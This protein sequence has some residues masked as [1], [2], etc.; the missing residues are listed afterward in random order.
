[1][2]LEFIDL[3]VKKSSGV[4]IDMRHSTAIKSIVSLVVG[5]DC[6]IVM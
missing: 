4:L 3:K 2:N 5:G 6:T 1:M